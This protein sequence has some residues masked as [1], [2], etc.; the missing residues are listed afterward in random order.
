MES[1]DQSILESHRGSIYSDWCLWHVPTRTHC[2]TGKNYTQKQNTRIEY[3]ALQGVGAF[4]NLFD[5]NRMIII[6]TLLCFL[7]F[8]FVNRLLVTRVMRR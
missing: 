3:V 7:L 1:R 8:F 4:P 2:K 5:Q 6:A